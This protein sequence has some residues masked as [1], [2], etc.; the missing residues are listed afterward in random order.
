MHLTMSDSDDSLLLEPYSEEVEEE[1]VVVISS[2]TSWWSVLRIV[3]ITLLC[4]AVIW[5]ACVG[6]EAAYATENCL[7]S[8]QHTAPVLLT[9][10]RTLL[11]IHP[12]PEDCVTVFLSDID[13]ASTYSLFCAFMRARFSLSLNASLRGPSSYI[14]RFL[15]HVCSTEGG[16]GQLG[17]RRNFSSAVLTFMVR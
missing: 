7:Y 5:F 8:S 10:T 2:S 4:M 15:S 11:Q 13:D 12:V 9:I 14:L 17:T 6:V 3:V 16:T 1:E